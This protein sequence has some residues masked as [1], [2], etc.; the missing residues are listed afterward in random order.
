MNPINEDTHI[1]DPNLYETIFQN[2]CI[3]DELNSMTPDTKKF[4][5]TP[6]NANTSSEAFLPPNDSEDESK[7]LIFYCSN[8]CL[9]NFRI[10]SRLKC[11]SLTSK[12]I[13]LVFQ[14]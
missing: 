11:I 5:V 9:K 7:K 2:W 12:P 13:Q 10:G 3:I 4:G 14:L 8:D 1:C 6:P